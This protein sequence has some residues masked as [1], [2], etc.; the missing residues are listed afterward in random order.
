MK[1]N[2]MIKTRVSEFQEVT[3]YPC[4]RRN[5]SGDV[6]CFTSEYEGYVVSIGNPKDQAEIGSKQYGL[7]SA[8]ESD[9]WETVHGVVTT[10]IRDCEVVSEFIETIQNKQDEF[11]CIRKNEEGSI[12]IFNQHAEG[13]VIGS[14]D[15]EQ[16]TTPIFD[17]VFN[18]K[19]SWEKWKP[20]YGSIALT[21]T[22]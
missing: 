10:S 20:F 5:K 16:L 21:Q 18:T 7:I 3:T 1:V 19:E 2:E 8:D 15:S 4:F 12:A 9:V 17:I 11:P 13:V 22:K 6:M 14:T